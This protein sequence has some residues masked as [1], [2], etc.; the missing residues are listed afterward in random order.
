MV[1]IAYAS[2]NIMNHIGHYKD[3]QVL[4]LFLWSIN[5]YL[6]LGINFLI[7]QQETQFFS[8]DTHYV[9][10]RYQLLYM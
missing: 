10:L 2:V 5:E 8:Y 7:S 9:I 4:L 3:Y 1:S 6:V